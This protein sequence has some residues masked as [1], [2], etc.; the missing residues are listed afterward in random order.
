MLSTGIAFKKMEHHRNVEETAPEN[1]SVQLLENYFC[2]KFQVGQPEYYVK[3]PGRVN[4]IGEHVDYCGY[5]VFPMA[6]DQCIIVAAKR[7]IGQNTIRLT[8]LNTE[9]YRDVV[10]DL[11]DINADVLGK[12]PCWSNYFLCGVK[13][14]QEYMKE[15]QRTPPK[16]VGFVFAVVGNIPESSGLSSSSAL[17]TAAVTAILAGYGVPTTRHQLAEISAKCERYIGTAGGGMDQAIAV[18]AKQGYASRIDFNPLTIKQ[19]RLPS[20]ATFIIAQSLATKNKA[21]SNDFNT[22]VVECRLASQIIAKQRGLDWK[23]LTVLSRLQ[24]N[25]GYTL[26]EMI[27]LVHQHLHVASYSKKEVCDLLSVSGD[28]LDRLSLTPNTRQ[29]PEFSLHQR[30]LHVFEEAKRMEQF[31][32][33]CETSASASK[34]GELMNLSHSSLRDLYQCSHPDLEELIEL[35][36]QGGA[37]GC[38][39]TG[40]GWGGCIVVIVASSEAQSFIKF[41]KEQFYSK[42]SVE[43]K[44]LNQVI[45]ATNP[46]EGTCVYVSPTTVANQSTELPPLLR[47]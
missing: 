17:V 13:G 28:E 25:L 21:A 30:A 1:A 37:Y 11:T 9:Q 31:C 18:H 26:D 38:K 32:E 16:D 46:S 3:V 36:L 39:L 35:C 2:Q 27:E 6:I 43:E 20:D 41:I 7:L 24:K 22:R 29:V 15:N 42:K 47:L 19:F 12:S 34:L 8:N 14:A 5:S 33:E 23:Q 44:R 45:F 4:L 10:H 40:A